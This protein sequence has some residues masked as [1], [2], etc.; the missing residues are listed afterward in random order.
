MATKSSSKNKKTSSKTS[1]R[2]AS[3][4]TKKSAVA[5]DCT[6]REC[7]EQHPVLRFHAVIL[8]VLSIIVCLLV[9]ILLLALA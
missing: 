7:L 1:G 2:T 5:C 8:G 9:A 3:A 6:V 4:A